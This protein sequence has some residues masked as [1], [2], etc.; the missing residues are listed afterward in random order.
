MKTLWGQ[1]KY[2][3]LL[4]TNHNHQSRDLYY[5]FNTHTFL[6]NLN[7]NKKETPR[8]FALCNNQ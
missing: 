4:L 2:S 8:N 1:L 5:N 7:N 3:F 6:Q